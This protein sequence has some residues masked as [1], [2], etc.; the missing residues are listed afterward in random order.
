MINK[1]SLYKEKKPS[2]E[3]EE[4]ISSFWMHRNISEYPKIV[5]ISPDGHF[6]ILIFVKD[7]QIIKYF[8]TGLWI[9]PQEFYAPPLTTIYGCRMK[10]LAPEFL[11]NQE[12]SPILNKVKQ[13]DLSYMNMV[14]FDV[15]EFAILIDQWEQELFKIKS[16]KPIPGNKIK[17]SQLIY[18]MKG[19]ISAKEVSE[20]SFWSNRQINRYLNK[21][22]GVSLKK[23][24]NIQKCYE[25]YNH[26]TEGRLFPENNYFDQSHFIREVKRYTGETPTKIFQQQNDR[27]V[28]LS[29]IK[30]K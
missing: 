19:D 13:L 18:K 1:K 27:F 24:L 14:N 12:V 2:I 9:K 3:L 4:F 6:K 8:M 5:T 20:Q 15:S 23:Y 16:G 11:L 29:N 30:R 28:Q 10:I 7:D 21:Y 25:S 17:L 26:I 22:L